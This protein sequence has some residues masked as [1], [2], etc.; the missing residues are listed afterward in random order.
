MYDT[1]Q[2]GDPSVTNEDHAGGFAWRRFS[3]LAASSVRVSGNTGG[4][5]SA[6]TANFIDAVRRWGS[7]ARVRCGF[8]N[9]PTDSWYLVLIDT[10]WRSYCATP[11]RQYLDSSLRSE[12][13]DVDERRHDRNQLPVDQLLC[14]RGLWAGPCDR[15][16]E[17]P[18]MEP[19]GAPSTSPL[20]SLAGVSCVS[21]SF[22]MA[23]GGSGPLDRTR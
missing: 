13:D 22:C 1:L 6:L 7:D 5:R 3:E 14:C 19:G 23:V 18:G 12:P 15:T 2:L 20:N 16:M 8:G 17:W 10:F 4:V 21:S 9:L 11:C